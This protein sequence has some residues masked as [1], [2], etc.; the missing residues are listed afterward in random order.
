MHFSQMDTRDIW[1]TIANGAPVHLTKETLTRLVTEFHCSIDIG[2]NAI[3][4]PEQANF[5]LTVER[6]YAN[7]DGQL[8][9]ARIGNTLHLYRSHAG[10]RFIGVRGA[11]QNGVRNE[12]AQA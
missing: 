1:D 4:G 8:S 6:E 10:G 2:G 3:A 11:P 12:N 7:S 5:L 9:V